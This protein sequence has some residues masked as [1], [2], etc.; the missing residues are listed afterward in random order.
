MKI[1]DPTANPTPME[2]SI[3]SVT[4]LPDIVFNL[5]NIYKFIQHVKCDRIGEVLSRI[6]T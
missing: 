3:L 6:F 4:L 1:V 2:K 5:N